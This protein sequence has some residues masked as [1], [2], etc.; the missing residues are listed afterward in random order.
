M[1][2][3]PES[4]SLFSHWESLVYT[5]AA[6]LADERTAPLAAPITEHLET[7]GSVLDVD[8]TTRRAG[9][10]ANARCSVRDMSLDEVIRDVQST[11]LFEVRQDRSAPS[12]KALFKEAI[13]QIV[14]HA[15]KRQVEVG[16]RLLENLGLSVVPEQVRA[17]GPALKTALDQGRAVLDERRTAEVGRAEARITIAEW[18][19]ES[20][21]LRL[22]VYSQLLALA[23]KERLGRS[24]PE[25]FFPGEPTSR[26]A[27][28][29]VDDPEPPTLT[30][31]VAVA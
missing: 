17:K 26:D 11:S 10:Q 12:Y 16:Q 14:R 22:A 23:A 21:A 31:P 18:K 7:F 19:E 13:S 5:E 1:R 30:P 4:H 15:L 25:G 9:V 3:V 20:N 8:M 2:V 28:P 29:P 24:W 6:L 27:E